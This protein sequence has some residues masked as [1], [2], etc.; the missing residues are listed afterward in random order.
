MARSKKLKAGEGATVPAPEVE[1]EL[2][3][4]FVYGSLR[5]GGALHPYLQ[6]PGA[7]LVQ[8]GVTN[9]VLFDL[10][11]FPGAQKSTRE[12]EFVQGEVYKLRNPARALGILD[13]VEGYRPHAPSAS[14]FLRET[15]EVRLRNGEKIRAWIYWLNRWMGATRR[16]PSGDYSL[17]RDLEALVK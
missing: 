15:V 1:T 5:K 7:A 10:G 3:L 9:G 17:L 6:G 4:L 16:I 14:L 8:E 11:A 2:D 12:N 13:E